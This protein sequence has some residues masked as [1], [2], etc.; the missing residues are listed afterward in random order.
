MISFPNRKLVSCIL[1]LFL[2]QGFLFAQET[3]SVERTNNKVILEGT[4]YYIHTVK[5]GETLYAISR[6]YNVSQKA[7]A[8]EN[9]GVVSGIQIGQALK[10]PVEGEPPE[11]IDTSKFVKSDE[12]IKYHTVKPGETLYGISRLYGLKEEDLRLSNPDISAENIAP[13]QQ[14]RIPEK[15]MADEAH[16]YNEE[17]LLYHKVKR[18]E[19]LY[20]IAAYYDVSID[21]IR[22]VNPE[23]GWGGP[24]AGQI[25]RIPESQLRNQPDPEE[26]SMSGSAKDEYEYHEFESRRENIRR[27]YRIA[28][29][30]PF[31]FREMEPLDSL[32]KDVTSET[33]KSRIIERYLME[34]K[35]P[36]SVHFLEFF[37]GTLLAIDS[38][39]QTGMKLEVQYFDTRRSVVRTSAILADYGLDDYDLIVGP[40]Y[41]YNL[42]LVS[43][44]SREH[45]IPLV[46]PF[47][48]DLDLIRDN[49]YLFQVSPSLEREYKDAAKLVA[50]KYSY[51]IVYVR[52]TDSL[53]VEK[54]EYFKQLIFDGFD[55]YHPS[56]PVV[57]KEVVQELDKADE[58]IFSLSEDKKNLVVVPTA[59]EALASSVVSALYYQLNRF[60]IEL[61]GAPQWTEFSSIDFRYYHELKLVFFNS[62]WVDYYDPEIEKFMAKFRRHYYNEPTVNSKKGINYGIL[63]HDMSLYFLNAMRIH[64]R[65]FILHLDDYHPRLVQGPYTFKRIS[66][67]GGYENSQISF[68]KFLPD[69]SI[70]KFTVPPLPEKNFFFRPVDDPNKRKYLYRENVIN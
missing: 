20:S 67:S 46:T 27:T 10:I 59:D 26:E 49:P 54:H 32:I 9:P 64:G 6:V 21:G 45:K 69:M 18:K 36:Q 35:I 24:K 58:L 38:M 4:V 28:Y 70:K 29:L 30:I 42:E 50:S 47:H 7:I 33:R 62:F 60:D 25:I 5:P 8:I 48:N 37:Q 63:G 56:E 41:P 55:D 14:L 15:M 65:R 2:L 23:L 22:A 31:D 19:T 3:V 40:F 53:D 52:Q 51:N 43:I 12:T 68:Y 44:F 16:P 61:I 34:E 11:E 13:G 1:G 66:G 17:G 57:F 39:R